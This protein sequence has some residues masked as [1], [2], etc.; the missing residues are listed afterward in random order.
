MTSLLLFRVLCF[1]A[2][3]IV[4]IYLCFIVAKKR[5][6]NKAN[7]HENLI[8]ILSHKHVD[9]NLSVSLLAIND[10]HVVI[11]TSKNAIALK[12]LNK[13]TAHVCTKTHH[14]SPEI[15]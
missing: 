2:A 10:D 13:R 3:I 8:T 12:L 6:F 9:Q 4:A 1:L 15:H 14:H 7:P 5:F 11:A